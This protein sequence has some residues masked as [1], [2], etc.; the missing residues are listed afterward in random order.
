MVG[1]KVA[2]CALVGAQAYTSFGFGCTGHG[3]G[4]AHHTAPCRGWGCPSWRSGCWGACWTYRVTSVLD[5][6]Y[7]R[8]R[9]RPLVLK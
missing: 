5:K 7:E 2:P 1:S 6:D 3:G 8:G 9:E 4:H